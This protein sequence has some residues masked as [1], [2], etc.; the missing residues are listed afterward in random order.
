VL[1]SSG[2]HYPR[3]QY[4]AATSLGDRGAQALLANGAG[5]LL[6]PSSSVGPVPPSWLFP[7]WAPFVVNGTHSVADAS[8]A[9]LAEHLFGSVDPVL[10]ANHLLAD[11]AVLFFSD[12]QSTLPR[13]VT[14][15][16]PLRWHPGSRFFATMLAGLSSSP[17][18]KSVTLSQLFAQVPPGSAET[19]LITRNLVA[20]PTTAADSLSAG[21]I[22]SARQQLQALHSLAPTQTDVLRR[23]ER[24]LLL[25]ES[26]RMPLATRQE[27]LNSVGNQLAREAALVSLPTGRTITIT[28]LS[29]KLPISI[30]SKSSTPL[31]VVLALSSPDLG[32][33]RHVI[34]L[35]LLPRNNTVNIGVS[36]RT[37]GD[38]PVRLQLLTPTGGVNLASGTL[39]IHS[40]AISGV[41]VA[42]TAGAGAFL[43]LWWSRSVF[44]KRRKGKHLRS[45]HPVAVPA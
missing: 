12:S 34:G 32:F 1:G 41:A 18:I 15:L 3:D 26:S 16:S 29:A 19:P 10:R 42:L 37:S 28:S 25:S 27:Y 40:T 31:K 8:D 21:L 39:E 4:V 23:N 30:Y 6:V 13:G 36:A 20:P 33:T 35:T 11:L 24:L 45:G 14:L 7:V 9:G 5:H 38:F 22:A 2:L 44:R 17:I 43:V